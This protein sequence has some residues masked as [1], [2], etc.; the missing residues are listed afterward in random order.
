[1]EARYWASGHVTLYLRRARG[2][3]PGQLQIEAIGLM[4]EKPLGWVPVKGKWLLDMML[5]ESQKTICWGQFCYSI[6]AFSQRIL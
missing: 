6:F 5:T 3:P 2:G 4:A 1:M